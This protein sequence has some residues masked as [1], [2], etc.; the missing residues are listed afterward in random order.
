MSRSL[1]VILI[2]SIFSLGGSILPAIAQQTRQQSFAPAEKA[3]KWADKRLTKMT[4]EEK[5]G[6]VIQIGINA[7][8]ANQNSDFFKE[9]RRQVVDNKIGGVIFFGAPIYETT[10]LINR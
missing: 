1:I 6:Q 2:I 4:V 8:F 3:W 10:H 7:R 9:L 5:V